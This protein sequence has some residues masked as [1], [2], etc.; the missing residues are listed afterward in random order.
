MLE[1]YF[2]LLFAIESRTGLSL[3]LR[4]QPG[5]ILI[6]LKMSKLDGFE[7]IEAYRK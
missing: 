2:K 1:L 4:H 7:F 3:A 6:D 5:L